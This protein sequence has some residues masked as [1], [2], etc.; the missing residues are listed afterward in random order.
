MIDELKNIPTKVHLEQFDVGTFSR[1]KIRD[2]FR[3]GKVPTAEAMVDEIL[4]RAAREGATDLH[5]EPTETDLRIRLGF[6]GVMKKLVYLPREIAENLSNVVKTKGNLNAFEKKKPQ[7]GRFSFM[8]G[9]IQFDIRIN[10]LPVMSGERIALRLFQHNT[11]VASIQE[12]GFSPEN[13]DKI[14]SLVTRPSGFVLFTGAAG[15]GKSST[16]YAVLGAAQ[17]PEKSIMTVENPVEFRLDFASQTAVAPAQGFNFIDALQACLRQNP[18]IIMISEI[19]DAE[20]ANAAAE[21]ALTGSL[22]ISSLLAGEAVGAIYRLLNLGASPYLISSAL[23][24]VAHQ[25][26]V[27]TICPSCKEEYQPTADEHGQFVNIIAGSTKFFRGKGCEKCGGSGYQGRS[28]IS[29][30]LLVNDQMRDLIY[31]KAPMSKLKEAAIASGFEN[32]FQDALKKLS[33]GETTITELRRAV[34]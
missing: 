22:I 26:L 10:V 13:L 20:M 29:E 3:M 14:K 32:I 24:G 5:I 7:E 9:P 25:H 15:S 16:I 6:E 12:L 17:S 34:G 19:R 31:Q 23:T 18:N 4:L 8:A 28:A 11:R 1:D 27:R 30:V 21:S 2:L 33:A